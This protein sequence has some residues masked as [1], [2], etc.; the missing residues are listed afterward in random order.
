MGTAAPVALALDRHPELSW[1][2]GWIKLGAIAGM[3]S[4]MLVMMLGQPR[5][6]YAMSVDGLLPKFF[7]KVHP[8]HKTPYI[9]TLITGTLAAV[10]AG[11]FPVTILGEL[12][13]IGTL[14]A[15][16]TVCIGV[17]V[18]RYSQPDLKRPFRVRAPW[19]VCIGGALICSAM[20]VSLPHDTW[21]RLGVWT[22]IGFLIYVFYGFRN[23]ALRRSG[24]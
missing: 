7:R 21:L 18:L 15:F 9:G 22:A 13:S 17:L 14:L 1:L 6:F 3:T 23:S 11:L 20:M 4:V 10:I 24:H 2:S 19:L 5:I 12:V 8:T 16:T